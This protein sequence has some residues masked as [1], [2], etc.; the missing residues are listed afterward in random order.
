MKG[1][2]FMLAIIKLFFFNSQDSE[3]KRINDEI[4]DR[5]ANLKNRLF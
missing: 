4:L 1:G 3:V 2:I 5:R